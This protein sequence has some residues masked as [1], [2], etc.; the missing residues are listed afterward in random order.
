MDVH[1]RASLLQAVQAEFGWN[2][3]ISSN[4]SSNRLERPFCAQHE[5]RLRHKIFMKRSKLKICKKIHASS[6]DQPMNWTLRLGITIVGSVT[7]KV[8]TA[9]LQ[10]SR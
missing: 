10:R 6:N 9:A 8:V 1:P 3:M 2:T 5:S 7:M 4:L